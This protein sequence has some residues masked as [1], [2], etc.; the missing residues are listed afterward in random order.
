MERRPTERECSQNLPITSSTSSCA[1]PAHASKRAHRVHRRGARKERRVV[2]RTEDSSR[3]CARELE[4]A[5][6]NTQQISCHEPRGSECLFVSCRFRA[7]QRFV[8]RRDT[9]VCRRRPRS[10]EQQQ[11]TRRK[12][13]ESKEGAGPSRR[14][15]P[16][17]SEL[18]GHQSSSAQPARRD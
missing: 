4:R 8:C 12:A 6:T 13:R 1:L 7:T 2:V 11:R 9:R 16:S 10:Q 18:L 3:V 15:A 17:R 14:S 5:N